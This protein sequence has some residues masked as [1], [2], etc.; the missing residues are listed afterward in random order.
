MKTKHDEK[1][2]RCR[3]LGQQIPFGYCRTCNNSIPCK[4]IYDCWFQAFDI[5]KFINEHYSQE[6]IAKIKTPNQG[7]MSIIYDILK[8]HKKAT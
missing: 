8:K 7:R 6:T 3:M 1:T 4:K 2:M 5:E